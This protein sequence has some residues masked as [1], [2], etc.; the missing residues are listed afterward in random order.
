MTSGAPVGRS[1]T[2]RGSAWGYLLTNALVM[3]G[4]GS[5]L[6]GRRV[7]YVQGVLALVGAGMSLT[8]AVV[9]LK[10]LL[11]VMDIPEV[12]LKLR[13][14]GLAGMGLFLGSWLWSIRT[15]VLLVRQGRAGERG[16][17]ATPG[18][19]GDSGAQGSAGS[20]A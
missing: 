6:A 9:Y 15:G 8:F 5:V 3:P 7:G 1:P 14:V 18:T 11:A 20:G 4:L 10:A 13:G 19:P 2:D 16:R 17:S 12:S